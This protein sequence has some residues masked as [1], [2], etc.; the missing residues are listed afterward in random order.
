MLPA[1]LSVQVRDITLARRGVIKPSDLDLTATLIVR[2]VGS[3][4]I[5][6]PKD[7]PMVPILATPGSGIIVDHRPSGNRLFS[8]PTEVPSNLQNAANPDGTY[9]FTGLTDTVILRDALAYPSPAIADPNAQ[10]AANDTRSSTDTETLMRGYV[11]DNIGPTAPAARRGLL[12]QQ[13]TVAANSHRGAGAQASPRFTNLLEL[14]QELG[15]FAGLG[16][17]VI[18]RGTALVFEV[19]T[20]TDRSGLILLDIN[21]GTISS[22]Q[23]TVA[24]PTITRAI[25]AG[26]GEGVDRIMVLRSSTASTAAEGDWGRVIEEFIDQR[27]TTDTAELAQKGDAELAASGFTSIAI[28]IVAADDVTMIYG[29]DWREGDIVRINYNGTPRTTLVTAAAIIANSKRTVV[30]MSIGDTSQMTPAGR[31][32]SATS[33]NTSDIKALQANTESSG[34]AAGTTSRNNL[35]DNGAFRTNQRGY[36]SGG[37]VPVGGYGHDRW[38]AVFSSGTQYSFAATPQGQLITLTGGASATWALRQR[39]ERAKMPAGT[40]TLAWDGTAQA[41][42]GNVGGIGPLVQAS[43]PVTF[44]IDGTDDVEVQFLYP[45]SAVTV[46]NVRLHAG[47]F[48]LGFVLPDLASEIAECRRYYRRYY[49]GAGLSGGVSGGNTSQA[50]LRATFD[51]PMRTAPSSVGASGQI[52]LSDDYSADVTASSA[53][54]IGYDGTASGGRVIINGFAGALTNGRWYGPLGSGT[55]YIEFSADF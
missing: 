44:T 41:R 18:Q 17:Q 2:D 24:P 51:P 4:K 27:Q 1:D 20:L 45:G 16:F 5:T 36:V 33:S 48:D 19:L 23:A 39:I 32:A 21:S 34:A 40:Y 46:G 26:G 12:A 37:A 6:L 42:I 11:A 31:S 28:K 52:K 38:G 53:A 22:Q 9:T 47:A 49:S 54:V 7:H 29:T 35:I 43:S 15:L 25:V 10:T 3:W 13:L 14:E 8:G 55:G 30:G 50:V